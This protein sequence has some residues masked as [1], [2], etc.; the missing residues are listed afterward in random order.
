MLVE[1]SASRATFSW[2]RPRACLSSRRSTDDE[3]VIVRV[4]DMRQAST[5]RPETSRTVSPI[6]P[7][8]ICPPPGEELSRWLALAIPNGAAAYWIGGELVPI[9]GTLPTAPAVSS[10]PNPSS[11]LTEWQQ[12]ELVQGFPAR[13]IGAALLRAGVEKP[14]VRLALMK[15]LAPDPIRRDGLPAAWHGHRHA[16]CASPIGAMMALEDAKRLGRPGVAVRVAMEWD[17]LDRSPAVLAAAVGVSDGAVSHREG[18]GSFSHYDDPR[19]LRDRRSEGRLV[20]HTLGAWPWAHAPAG[21]LPKRWHE[22]EQFTVPLVRWHRHAIAE[23]REDADFREEGFRRVGRGAVP[24][25]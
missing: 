11:R 19:R 21:R 6:D 1:Q 15:M 23:L 10:A 12:V 9:T 5:S 18:D 3:V 2:L 16:A 24:T 17:L 8:S 14:R 22:Q 25:D 7:R 4:S 20:L 13:T